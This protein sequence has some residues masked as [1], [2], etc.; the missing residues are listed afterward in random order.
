MASDNETL[1][2]VT[3]KKR[4]AVGSF[5]VGKPLIFRTRQAART[6]AAARNKKSRYY[7]YQVSP[8]KWGPEQ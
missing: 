6:Y 1:Y 2:L 3:K 5:I 8:A 4:F 7:I